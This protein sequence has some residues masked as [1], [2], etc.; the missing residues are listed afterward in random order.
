MQ[1]VTPFAI[2]LT[3]AILI[4]LSDN[5]AF[6]GGSIE[7]VSEPSSPYRDGN[8]NGLADSITPF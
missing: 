4:D 8:T 3:I 2:D 7:D 5:C 1:K 6:G